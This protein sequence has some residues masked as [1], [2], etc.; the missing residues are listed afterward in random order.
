MVVKLTEEIYDIFLLCGFP[1]RLMKVDIELRK[2]PFA[3]DYLS[4]FNKVMESPDPNT[5]ESLYFHGKSDAGKSSIAVAMAKSIVHS[6]RVNHVFYVNYSELIN[7]FYLI[8][9]GELLFKNS[10]FDKAMRYE[11]LVLDEVGIETK[12]TDFLVSKFYLIINTRYEKKMP[13]IITSNWPIDQLT[14]RFGGGEMADRIH[15]R[16][17]KMCK[18]VE[19]KNSDWE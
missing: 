11:F 16:I 15:S 5:Q 13:M 18:E 19:I 3:V 12:L 10:K 6:P 14:E 1:V 2:F 9:K 8:Q 7:E 4:N 17:M